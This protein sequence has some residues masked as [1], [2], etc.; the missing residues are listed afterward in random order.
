ME[1]GI[2]P[3][4][5]LY[6]DTDTDPKLNKGSDYIL[7]TIVTSD[8]RKAVSINCKGNYN[9]YNPISHDNSA[10]LLGWCSDHARNRLIMFLTSSYDD[11]I[12]YYD[13]NTE[14]N[15]LIIGGKSILNFSL[16]YLIFNPKIIGDLLYWIDNYNPPRKINY[17]RAYNY[18]NSISTT[19]KYN[20]INADIIKAY[21]KP[22]LSLVPLALTG[23]AN[24][25][26][27]KSFQ[28]TYRYIYTD[29]EKSVLA[30]FTTIFFS[31]NYYYPNG[32]YKKDYGIT[33]YRLTFNYFSE[34]IIATELYV[35][36]NERSNWFL[37]DVIN[38]P[39]AITFTGDAV[40]NW[41]N[42]I[43]VYSTDV[44]NSITIG[45]EV[46]SNAI[47]EGYGII[48]DKF[49]YGA[50]NVIILDSAITVG[51]FTFSFY[52]SISEGVINYVFTDNKL[53]ISAD[54]KDLARPFDYIPLLAEQQELIEKNRLIYGNITEGFDPINIDA[55]CSLVIANS[56]LSD[57]TFAWEISG[58]SYYKLYCNTYSV[59]YLYAIEILIYDSTTGIY[60]TH[61]GRYIVRSG[62]TN[63]FILNS[64][65]NSLNNSIG[66]NI[67]TTALD[68][69]PS[70]FKLIIPSTSGTKTIYLR[71]FCIY[72]Y[73]KTSFRSVKFGDSYLGAIT[74]YDKELRNSSV[75]KMA[76]PIVV[77]L[78]YTPFTLGAT[79]GYG[80]LNVSVKNLPPDWAYYYS[81]DFT[82]RVK[83]G[84][85]KQLVCLPYDDYFFDAIDK[86]LRI[87]V[88]ALIND[89][90]DENPHLNVGNYTFEKGD[91]LRII[92]VASFYLWYNFVSTWN[93]TLDV[94]I[95]NM[96]WPSG[97]T[98]YAKDEATTPS[99][100]TDVNGNKILS[101]LSS[102][103]KVP[104]TEAELVSFT[105]NIGYFSVHSFIGTNY[106]GDSLMVEIYRPKK[107]SDNPVYYPARMMEIGNP[108]LATRYHKGISQHQNP[109]NPTSVPAIVI[110]YPGDTYTK[111]RD[112][113]DMF[114]CQDDNYSDYYDSDFFGFGRPNFYDAN[115]KR[116]NLLTGLRY[117]GKLLE[118]TKV[119]ELNKF[120]YND[121]VVLKSEYGSIEY[122]KEVGDVL[123]VLQDK[124]E[125]S[126][127]VGL[128]EVKQ[129]DGSSVWMS[130][131]KV[132]GTQRK[133]DE[134]RGT[135]HP[136]S[137]VVN[138]RDM[139]Y[140]D[141]IRKEV[142]RS[143]PNG[144][145][146][147]SNYGMKTFFKNITGYT[148][149]VS[150][151]D[152]T[153][154]T[155]FITFV[156]TT[157][158]LGF[159]DPKI[160]GETPRWISYFSFIPENY[161]TI[162]T[163]FASFI[164]GYGGLYKHNSDL[165]NRC[166]FYD[167]K[168][169]QQI[170]VYFNDNPLIKKVFRSL[171]L[172]TNKAWSIPI[173]SIEA[174]ATYTRGFLSKLNTQHFTLKEGEYF[175]ELLNNMYTSSN[176]ASNLDLINGERLRGFYVKLQLENSEHIECWFIALGI[177]W[178]ASNYY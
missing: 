72:Y 60:Q 53:R 139:Y 45:A 141:D 42:S 26:R 35:R 136:K 88:N 154:N 83:I 155:F 98:Q 2:V 130:S 90:I 153:N 23:S 59:D 76:E 160:E 85:Y 68:G 84:W 168:Y 44:Y 117:S 171:C 93:K 39:Y 108:T 122:I 27:G 138:D 70:I 62:D 81:I 54:Q 78:Y 118:N 178:E 41:T 165:V 146:V 50:Y 1:K 79:N 107:E 119:N 174:D 29:G 176:V 13:T 14:A 58:G 15:G 87:R 97:D 32:E 37:Y 120:E 25:I 177:N 162:G 24:I 142:V 33:S 173:I 18:T 132:L 31:D 69:T 164:N 73:N 4:G 103:I 40:V 128:E 151:W 175:S 80:Y 9:I 71:R 48:V 143:S 67:V 77:P 105:D 6:L 61:N 150:G 63:T 95:E 43:M 12:E 161:I 7:N 22:G 96:E 149:V 49:T 28:W 104:I 167:T 145:I 65:K 5:N 94:E 125:T 163:F 21:K 56:N 34:D 135:K 47:N 112:L 111:L 64:I 16:S 66:S 82:E 116:S 114:V 144:Q 101:D 20:T 19:Y 121:L 166:T 17:I 89:A 30:P 10:Y 3:I 157:Y 8:G 172:K 102:Y 106:L 137:V 159:Y 124:K 74:Y 109:N 51:Y 38:K 92:G 11:T 140:W 115:A 123:K 152:E 52:N 133:M 158:T 36:D 127:Y 126:I 113:K 86:K 46:Y 57:Q 148:D 147:I 91:R 131:D 129:A 170:N 169:K 55:T 134:L 99:Y 156:G 110:C 75:N 100:K